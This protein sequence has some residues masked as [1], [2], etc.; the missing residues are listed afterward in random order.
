MLALSNAMFAS[1]VAPVEQYRLVVLLAPSLEPVQLV[2]ARLAVA[3]E[4]SIEALQLTSQ[5]KRSWS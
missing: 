1:R 3:T 2:L 4:Q 5:L